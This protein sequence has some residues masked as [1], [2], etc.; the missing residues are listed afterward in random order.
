MEFASTF[1]C[2]EFLWNLE[3]FEFDTVA[4]CIRA[5]SLRDYS[6]TLVSGMFITVDNEAAPF[7][8]KE[9]L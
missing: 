7:H 5:F 3:A 2:R 6:I 1:I 8:L 4:F 9:A